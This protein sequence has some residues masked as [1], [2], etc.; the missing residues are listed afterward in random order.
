MRSGKLDRRITIQRKSITQSDSGQEIVTWVDFET[1]WAEK[2]EAKGNERF[3]QQQLVGHALKTFRIRWSLRAEEITN[4]FRL[5]FDG[6]A[7][8]I[9]DVREDDR[10][11]RTGILI[12]CFARGEEPLVLRDAGEG[13]TFDSTLI[14][15][16]DTDYTMDDAA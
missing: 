6:R 14:T 5:M 15:F 16:D 12:D 2:I 9:T 11:R 13:V 3:A 7:H 1:V 10:G 8:D 4:E